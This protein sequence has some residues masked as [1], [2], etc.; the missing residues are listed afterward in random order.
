MEII[1]KIAAI[2]WLV[3]LA[4]GILFGLASAVGAFMGGNSERKTVSLEEYRKLRSDLAELEAENE[5]LTVSYTVLEEQNAELK[6]TNEAY[7]RQL[8]GFLQ[9]HP[10]EVETIDEDEINNPDDYKYVAR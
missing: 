10:D 3:I 9:R 7:W 5:A 1:Y 6:E 2:S 8:S 4:L